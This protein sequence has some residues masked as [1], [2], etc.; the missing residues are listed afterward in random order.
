MQ[1]NDI[2]IPSSTKA[3]KYYQIPYSYPL[4]RFGNLCAHLKKEYF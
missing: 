4:R 2:T 3:Q 1:A